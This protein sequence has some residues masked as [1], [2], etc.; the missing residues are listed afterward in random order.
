MSGIE[1]ISG[2]SGGVD[3]VDAAK[4]YMEAAYAEEASTA[5][6][7]NVPSNGISS[8]SDSA[9]SESPVSAPPGEAEAIKEKVLESFEK[10]DEAIE[11][12]YV[13][14]I[15]QD[16]DKDGIPDFLDATGKDS[17]TEQHY[18]SE[19]ERLAAEQHAFVSMLAMLSNFD[20]T[21]FEHTTVNGDP[22]S[23]SAIA[24]AGCAQVALMHSRRLSEASEMRPLGP[25]S[26]KKLLQNHQKK[27]ADEKRTALQNTGDLLA[28]I[29]TNE[30]ELIKAYPELEKLS[31]AQRNRMLKNLE[32]MKRSLITPA[33][34]EA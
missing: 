26:L 21:N 19:A 31:P 9:G 2:N 28:R 13:D 32:V 30:K 4:A 10:I 18:D 1:A 16:A 7:S 5:E 6:I 27:T 8:V 25:A 12:A 11:D 23:L 3:R 15:S 29:P 34:A 17:L 22:T 20:L 33:S 24:A 14:E